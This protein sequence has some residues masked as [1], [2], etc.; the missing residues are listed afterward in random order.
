MTIVYLWCAFS[1][2]GLVFALIA[3]RNALDELKEL[4]DI[5]NGRR[6]LGKGHVR[7]ESV[8]AGI[9][10]VW[11]LIGL[12]YVVTQTPVSNPVV[13]LPLLGTNAALAF[14]TGMRW[15]DRRYAL[16]ARDPNV[17]ETWL[18]RQYADHTRDPHVPETQDQRE[19]RWFGEQR[20]DLEAE[21]TEARED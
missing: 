19:D 7:D 11:L 8:V 9:D 13:A 16:H 15:L 10:F 14:S 6:R 3:R 1:L 21:H 17:P 5:T 2:A 20:R 4:G 18:D 12:I